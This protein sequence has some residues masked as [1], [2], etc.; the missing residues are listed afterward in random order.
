MI[1][2]SGASAVTVRIR[3]GAETI[4]LEIEDNGRGI[5]TDVHPRQ[6]A[7][8][9]MQGLKER[10]G[11]IGGDFS[12]VSVPGSG[13]TISIAGIPYRSATAEEKVTL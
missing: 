5:S 11:Q 7:G 10:A 12:I 3:L 13:T 4:S 2:H 6:G 8:F 1:K 9:G